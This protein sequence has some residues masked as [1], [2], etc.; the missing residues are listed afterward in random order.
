VAR[1]PSKSLTQ[2]EIDAASLVKWDPLNDRAAIEIRNLI[3][4]RG[5]GEI[6][7][8]DATLVPRLH[9]DST[10]RNWH[11]EPLCAT[12]FSVPSEPPAF[13]NS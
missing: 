8:L 1:S 2:N 12:Q 6:H 7:Y 4:I 10:S 11:K 5:I 3:G 9:F 13:C